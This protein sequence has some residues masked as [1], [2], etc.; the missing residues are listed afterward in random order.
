MGTMPTAHPA[1]LARLAV[2]REQPAESDPP[3]DAWLRRF[4]ALSERGLR[5]TAIREGLEG[6]D[7]ASLIAVL[8]R[9]DFRARA[10]EAD[11]RWFLTELAVTPSILHELDYDRRTDLYAAARDA[12]YREVASRFLGARPHPAAK[13]A[14]DN[15]HVELT[16]GQRT[17]AA[18]T[19][20]RLLLDR[21]LHDRD[22]RVIRALLDNPRIVE[23]DVVKIAALRPTAP[24]VLN[25]IANHERWSTHYRVRKSLAFNPYSPTPLARQLLRTLLRQDLV[26]LR[27]SGTIAPELRADA[28]LLL[29][30]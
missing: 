6:F 14:V 2:A 9:L 24:E 23:R 8:D 13:T 17:S 15:P 19:T 7:D 3:L 30:G 29:S 12:G 11:C 18:K 27:D 10:G 25:T 1:V 28:N 16:P 21:L 26:A 5:R 4:K 20:D 22:P